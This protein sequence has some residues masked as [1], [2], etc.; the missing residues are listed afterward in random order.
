MTVCFPNKT[1]SYENSEQQVLIFD[2]DNHPIYPLDLDSET[3]SYYASLNSQDT[4]TP[5]LF[6]KD[7][8][9]TSF[10]SSK[11]GITTMLITPTSYLVQN[12]QFYLV[13]CLAFFVLTF[14]VLT[15]ITH[16]LA[17]RI[18]A[19]LTELGNRISSFELGQTKAEEEGHTR[20]HSFNELEILNE[21]YDRMQERLKQ[22]LED[23][24]SSR[25]LTIHSQM[26]ALQA[27]MD[28][29]F[30]YNTLT[31]ISIIAED[32]EDEQ[33][34][35]MCVKL[36]QMLRYITEDISRDTTLAQELAHT[37]NYSDLLSIRFGN[38]ID[39]QYT[40][41][42]ALNM[43]RVPR[44]I[45]QPLVENC[46]KYSRKPQKTLQIPI[47]SWISENYWYINITDNGDGFS[48]TALRELQ[49]KTE[50]LNLERENPSL[51][52]NGLGLA[53]IYLRLKLYYKEQ[54]V[55]RL[56]NK[57]DALG[58]PRGASITIGGILDET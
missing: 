57:E 7:E 8:L 17:H 41:E 1:Q 12:R 35:S 51:T 40:L 3:L 38:M 46:V 34:A 28:S 47:Q 56:E 22:S 9:V 42:P 14:G 26:T 31:I 33:A 18:T 32:N 6:L 16:R 5:S 25:T 50:R 15:F 54:F 43:V 53:N 4:P 52:I 37:A 45:V 20:R 55:F 36:T 58:S 29:H 48:D 44:L 27:Q 2:K 49:E 30:L 10:S 11:T 39:F 19:P 13:I 21:S 24:V 23:V